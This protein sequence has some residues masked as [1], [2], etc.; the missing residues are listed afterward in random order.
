L[1]A[2]HIS[3]NIFT[4]TV[5]T[6]TITMVLTSYFIKFDNILYSRFKPFLTPFERLSGNKKDLEYIPE[7]KVDVILCGQDRLGYSILGT[8]RKLKKKLLVVDYNPE[9][10]KRLMK[11]KVP[12]IYGDISDSEILGRLPFKNAEMVISTV[13]SSR[14]N[15]LLIKK[16][17]ETNSK[18]VIYVTASSVEKALRLY[19]EGA[20]YVILPHFLGGEHVSL[21][22]ER[23]KDN[24]DKIIKNKAKHINELKQR[25]VMGHEHPKQYSNE[26]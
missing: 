17:K 5:L 10:I 13:P 6:A 8:V 16:V 25:Q 22:I 15:S 4:L 20:D 12:C 14:V 26:D 3:N 1:L 11:E 18:A 23:C 19:D 21:L 2:G 9:I 24:A 7:K